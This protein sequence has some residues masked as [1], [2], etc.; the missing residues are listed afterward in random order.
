[1]RYGKLS[2]VEFYSCYLQQCLSIELF[3]YWTPGCGQNGPINKVCSSCPEVFLE[4]ALSFF[5]ELS[6]VLGAHVVSCMTEPYFLKII[7]C[8]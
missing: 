4:L 2:C 7:F 8:L 1:M 6:I 5:L 3:S